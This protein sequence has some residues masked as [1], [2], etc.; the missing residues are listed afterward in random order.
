[1]YSEEQGWRG[2]PEN[3]TQN[4]VLRWL[5]KQVKQ[6][7]TFAEEEGFPML[8]N[9]RTW[10]RPEQPLQ[11]STADRKLDI[12]FISKL[13]DDSPENHWS[14]ILIPGELKSNPSADTLSQTWLDLGRYVREVFAAQDNR[15]FVLGFTLCGPVMRL[16]EFDRSG[17]IASTPFDINK[18]GHLFVSVLLGYFF[19]WMKRNSGSIQ[20]LDL[21]MGCALLKYS[22]RE[23]RNVSL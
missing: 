9:R 4:E 15:R 14:H 13:D 23:R 20:L 10:A 21:C 6:L 16:W 1:L 7:V 5:T 22:V 19:G 12:A 3:A 11:G 2:W 18:D 8:T 17:V